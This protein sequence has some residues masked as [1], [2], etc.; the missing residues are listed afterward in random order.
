MRRYCP[1]L[2]FA[3]VAITLLFCFPSL[4]AKKSAYG[5]SSFAKYVQIPGAKP[6][7]SDTCTTCHAEVANN[8][9]HAFHAQQ[10]VDCEECHGAGSLHVEGGGDISKIISFSHRS[11]TDANGVCLSCHAKDARL[12]NWIA[13]PHASNQVRCTECHQTHAYGAKSA[14]PKE[15]SFNLMTPGRVT[16]VED[17]VPEAKASDELAVAV[18]LKVG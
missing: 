2:A 9:R 10:G 6:V 5:I 7:G 14:S 3:I 11:A 8:F 18:E 13:G 17:L 12:R 1:L 4:A 15:A 16:A